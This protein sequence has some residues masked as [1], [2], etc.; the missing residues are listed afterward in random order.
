MA[1]IAPYAS[2]STWL[3]QHQKVLFQVTICLL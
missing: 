1:Y 3:K 2:P